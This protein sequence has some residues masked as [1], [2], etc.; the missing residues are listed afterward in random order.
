MTHQ[1]VLLMQHTYALATN[2]MT[3]QPKIKMA[4]IYVSTT[5]HIARILFLKC[6][7]KMAVNK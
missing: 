6:A 1:L 5:E 4:N 7:R 3:K 2:D